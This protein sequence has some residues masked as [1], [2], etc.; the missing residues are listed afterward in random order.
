MLFIHSFS[1]CLMQLII[2]I[3]LNSSPPSSDCTKEELSTLSEVRPVR[4]FAT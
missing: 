2:C 4:L 3:N 1:A